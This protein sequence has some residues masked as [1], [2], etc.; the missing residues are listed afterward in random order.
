[1]TEKTLKS[2][3]IYEG[4]IVK[5]RVE[6]VTLPTNE[7]KMREI[8]N[9][10]GAAA[11]IPLIDGKVLLVSQ[12]RKAIEHHTLE[13]P[14]GLL[15]PEEPP[16]DCAARELVEET[17]YRAGKLTKIISYYSSPGFTDEVIHIFKASELEKVSEPEFSTEIISLEDVMA[18]IK[19]GKIRD[20]KT[21]IGIQIALS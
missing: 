2:K 19:S 16:E 6:E 20:G 4:R 11:I 10:P 21:I 15:K 17:G 3:R 5:L 12:Y 9:H 18:Q 14:A 8:V 7:R 1:M 13:I